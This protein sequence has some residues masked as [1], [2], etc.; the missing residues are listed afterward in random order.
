MLHPVLHLLLFPRFLVKDF[1]PQRIN[2]SSFY[3]LTG[4]LG[5]LFGIF[6]IA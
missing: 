3:N 1:S 2:A 6:Q 5:K 4:E